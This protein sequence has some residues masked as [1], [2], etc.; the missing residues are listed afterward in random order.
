VYLAVIISV[1]RAEDRGAESRLD[2]RFLGLN[3]LQ[4]CSL[5]LNSQCYCVYLSEINVKTILN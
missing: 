3:R 2:V 4:C 5:K 1:F